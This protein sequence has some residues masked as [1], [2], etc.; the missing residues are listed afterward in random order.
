MFDGHLSEMC[1]LW[2]LGGVL[3]RW[4][5]GLVAI[6][7]S[8]HSLFLLIISQVSDLLLKVEQYYWIF[9]PKVQMYL[10]PDVYSSNVH[11]SQTIKRAQMS[12][13][14]WKFEKFTNMWKID[15]T[16]LNN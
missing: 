7:Y 8:S 15:N 3:G 2:Q 9:T 16:S 11:N 12:I 4:L 14:R 5:L 10:H 6:Q 13:Y 1:M